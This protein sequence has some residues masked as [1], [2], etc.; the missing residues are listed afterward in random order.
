[1][2]HQIERSSFIEQKYQKVKEI[3]Q[4]S[5]IIKSKTTFIKTLFKSVYSRK[6]DSNKFHLLRKFKLWEMLSRMK[7]KNSM[8]HINTTYKWKMNKIQSINLEKITS[9][10]S[11]KLINWQEVLWAWWM[12]HSELIKLNSSH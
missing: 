4:I 6:K 10:T 2:N 8:I 1:M 12:K 5:K 7:E 11:S 3:L 9:E